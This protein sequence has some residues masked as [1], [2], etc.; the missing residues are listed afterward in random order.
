MASHQMMRSYL[1]LITAGK[2]VKAED[3]YAD[4]VKVHMKGH[5]VASGEYVGHADYTAALGKIMSVIDS[6]TVDEHDLL[7]SD[8]HAVVLSTWHVTRGDRSGSLNHCIIYHTSRD[9][10]TEIWIIPEDSEADAA[11]LS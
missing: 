3:F 10:I 6:L 11:L 1:D 9:K 7:V 5:N 4:D 2:F 8:D